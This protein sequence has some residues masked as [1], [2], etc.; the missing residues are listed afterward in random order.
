MIIVFR[1]VFQRIL[2]V[3]FLR[4]IFVQIIKMLYY[5][6]IDVSEGI[7]VDKT[8]A[9]KKCDIYHYWYFLNSV[10]TKCLQ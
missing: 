8:R 3:S 1:A 9:S 7:Y 10:S 5:D 2:S 6:G 4:L